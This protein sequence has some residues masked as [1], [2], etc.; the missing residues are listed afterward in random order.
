MLQVVQGK[1]YQVVVAYVG[2]IEVVKACAQ[3][4]CQ[5]R[6]FLQVSSV[7]PDVQVLCG[8]GK[9][10]CKVLIQIASLLDPVCFLKLILRESDC[11]NVFSDKSLY[12]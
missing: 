8:I 4:A 5:L 10:V 11:N 7:E 3:P 12:C 9:G 6:K 1:L 2:V